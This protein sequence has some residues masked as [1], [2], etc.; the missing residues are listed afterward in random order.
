MSDPDYRWQAIH[1]P[2][3]APPKTEPALAELFNEIRA[4]VEQESEIVRVV[5]PNPL[6][7]MQV[8]L[9]RIFAQSVSISLLN[10]I[11]TDP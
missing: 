9:Q 10:T 8:F 1:N 2:D 6:V 4:T 7:V 11:E 5:F 3:T